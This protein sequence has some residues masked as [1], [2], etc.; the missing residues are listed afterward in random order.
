M[1]NQDGT[2]FSLVAVVVGVAAFA[3][4]I[5]A[6]V[7]GGDRSD[8]ADASAAEVST[9]AVTLTEF[10]I[11]PAHISVPAGDA[12]LEI[13]NAGT[14][15]HNLSIPELGVTSEDVG[16]GETTTL[17]LGTVAVGDYEVLCTIAGHADAGMTGMLMASEGGSGAGA[18]G[19]TT[20]TTMSNEQM[21]AMMEEVALQFPAETDGHGGEQLEPTILAD[22]TKQFDLVAEI[23]DW[24]VEPGKL[25]EAWT[26]NGVVPA[27]EIH[28]EVGDHVKVVLK[29]ELPESTSLHFHG[30]RVPNA[31]DGVDPYTQD[32]IVPGETFTY[33]F[34]TQ[35][36]AVG[37]YHSHHN[38]QVQVP[39][40][41]AGAFLVGEM[42]IPDSLGVTRVEQ[43]VNMVLNDAGTL[44][45]SLNG[46]SF[47]ATEPYSLRVGE[48]MVVNYFNEGLMAHP[49][50]LHQPH[51][52]IIAKDGVP[53]AEPMSSDTVN[54]APGERW[55]VLYTARDPGVWAWHC[56]ILNHA[57]TPTGMKY[58]VT[59]LIVEE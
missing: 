19:T 20:P 10:A 29:N 11:S 44:G 2:T 38:A 22:G 47:P 21:D 23:V 54:V 24:E 59:A 39:N 1:T 52:W 4:A 46:K 37:M 33:E 31:M 15:A 56:H 13:T 42:P 55:T 34:T 40:G 57:E 53:L 18:A 26:Y 50:H 51:G 35:E 45:L 36:A 49:M 58:M 27:P 6:I 7:I 9:V 5:A 30:V 48:S 16:P 17:E 25:V 8:N 12:R 43:T 32:P 14:A 3:L 28:V 41:M